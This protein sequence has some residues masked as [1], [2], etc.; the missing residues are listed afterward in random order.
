MNVGKDAVS[1]NY[2]EKEKKFVDPAVPKKTEENS[3]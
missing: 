1:Q 2:T 3:K